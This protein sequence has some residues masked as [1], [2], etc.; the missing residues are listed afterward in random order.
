[1]GRGL[2]AKLCNFTIG[3]SGDYFK[4]TGRD[5]YL[6]DLAPE[7][8]LNGEH[9]I[10][11]DMYVHKLILFSSIF[12]TVYRW[13]FGIL[14]YRIATFGKQK[15]LKLYLF[16]LLLESK[17]PFKNIKPNQ[18]YEHISQGTRPTPFLPCYSKEL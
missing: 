12:I 3:Q 11:S 16:F 8:I 15:K 9:S 13:S 2:L 1:M 7:T 17:E 6:R 4:N 5:S 18:V 10:K 14:V